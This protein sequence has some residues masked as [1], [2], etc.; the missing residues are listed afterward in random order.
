MLIF[1]FIYE[2]HNTSRPNSRFHQGIIATVLVCAGK[3]NPMPAI[4]EL[5]SNVM[6]KIIR[7]S[8]EDHLRVNEVGNYLVFRK[9]IRI[10]TGYIFAAI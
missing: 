8:E 4:R 6:T 3:V 9:K 2:F 7:G 10:L 1:K 5:K